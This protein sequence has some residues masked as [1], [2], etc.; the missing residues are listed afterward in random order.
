M[1]L[2]KD[3]SCSQI[4]PGLNHTKMVNTCSVVGCKTNYKKQQGDNIQFPEKGH[5]FYFPERRPDL[6]AKWGKFI[7]R[8]SWEP[9]KSAGICLH[10][11]D[12]KFIKVG[13]RTTLKWELDPV[14][15]IYPDNILPSLLPTPTTF[16]KPPTQRSIIP[17]EMIQ[18]LEND[19]I[20]DFSDISESCCPQGYNVELQDGKAT[21]YMLYSRS[22][23]PIIGWGV[24]EGGLLNYFDSTMGAY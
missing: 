2:F 24:L 16:R 20:K 17:D 23:S 10:H 15:T 7:N 3:I 14:P 11:F 18:Y 12:L 6:K 21:F 22:W 9:H 1:H 8:K 19:E 5:V 13:Q 4:L